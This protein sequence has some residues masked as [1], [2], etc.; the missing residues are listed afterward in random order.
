MRDNE[1]QTPQRILLWDLCVEEFRRGS[2]PSAQNKDTRNKRREAISDCSPLEQR[3][4][5]GP[6]IAWVIALVNE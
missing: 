3:T 5:S 6:R 2:A 4:S 1:A